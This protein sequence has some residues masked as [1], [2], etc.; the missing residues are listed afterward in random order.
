VRICPSFS[1]LIKKNL[2][3]NYGSNLTLHK[4]RI[5]KR[6]EDRALQLCSP[7]ISTVE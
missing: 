7:D 4:E 2:P 6:E 5:R 3:Y 1:F